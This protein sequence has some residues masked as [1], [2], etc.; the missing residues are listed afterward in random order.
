LEARVCVSRSTVIYNPVR[1]AAFHF[2]SEEGGTDLVG[3]AG[4]LVREK[5]LDLLIHALRRLPGVRLE[6][7]GDGPLRG[8]YESCVEEAGIAKRVRFLNTLPPSGVADLLCRAAVVCVPSL[9]AEPFGYAVA[10]AMA[11]GRPVVATPNGAFLELLRDGRGFLAADSS[12]Q[13]LA[14]TLR[15]ALED[16]TEGVRAGE[17][18]RSF[19]I[20]NLSLDAL[21]PRYEAL[22]ERSAF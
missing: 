14:S 11:M 2:R 15:R 8:F 9:W 17:S 12:P 10:E 4:R 19:A 18:A 6:I 16:P 13:S 3:F 20:R 5:G 22:Y 7:A 21:G 1:T